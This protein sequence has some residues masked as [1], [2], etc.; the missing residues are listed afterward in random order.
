MSDEETPEISQPSE[1]P[2]DRPSPLV[3][4]QSG[5]ILRWWLRSVPS[6][7]RDK[8]YAS[9]LQSFPQRI[10]II[11]AV[12]DAEGQWSIGVILSG[13]LS[14][15]KGHPFRS[16]L[17]HSRLFQGL[18]REFY[19]RGRG[20][21]EENS[22]RYTLAIDQNHPLG[23]LS[24]LRFTDGGSPF[25]AGAKLPSRKVSSHTSN[26]STSSKVRNA[27][28]THRNKPFSSHS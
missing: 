5:F 4:L 13:L 6:V 22:Q 7:R 1:G 21:R 15:F 12:G 17:Q 16:V 20:R 11:G 18:F 28:Q 23:S 26:P 10:A 8:L 19:F 27:R 3:R 25:F 9:V 14:N 24:S 2:L